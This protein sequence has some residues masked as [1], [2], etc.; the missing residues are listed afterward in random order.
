MPYIS[1][2]RSDVHVDRPLSTLSVAFLQG[3]DDF[4]SDSVFPI[5]SVRS[6]SDRYFLSTRGDFNRA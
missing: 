2:S 4:V 3:A 5:V 6:R 1:P